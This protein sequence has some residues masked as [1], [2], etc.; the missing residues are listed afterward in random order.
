MP[1]LTNYPPAF[2]GKDARQSRLE[3]HFWFLR[4]VLTMAKQKNRLTTTAYH[5]N[6]PYSLAS[7][8]MGIVETPI[9]QSSY[10]TKSDTELP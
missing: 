10:R 8:K 1:A 7:H 9:S 3:R 5:H 4:A 2:V 6:L